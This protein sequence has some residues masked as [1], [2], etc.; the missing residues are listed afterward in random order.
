MQIKSKDLIEGA[1]ARVVNLLDK[2]M[3]QLEK[4]QQLKDQ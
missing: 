4:A 1:N 2:V 3:V